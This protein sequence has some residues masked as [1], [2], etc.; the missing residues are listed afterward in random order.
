MDDSELWIDSEDDEEY[1]EETEAA[2]A[3]PTFFQLGL[4]RV[5]Q[6]GGS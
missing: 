1:D 4:G 5:G 3:D 2:S 6:K